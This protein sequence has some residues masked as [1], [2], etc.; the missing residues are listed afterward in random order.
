MKRPSRFDSLIE[1]TTADIETRRM[2]FE[3][4]CRDN[5]D[6]TNWEIHT[7]GMTFAQLKELFIC[8][9]ILGLSFDVALRRLGIEMNPVEQQRI[10]A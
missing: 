4:L 7:D 3:S 6:I 9:H 5:E 10:C 1:I 8:V 2:Y